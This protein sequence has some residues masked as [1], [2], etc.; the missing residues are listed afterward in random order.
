MFQTPPSK[1]KKDK[2]KIDQRVRLA[3][4]KFLDA[5]PTKN[6]A[7]LNACTESLQN[8]GYYVDVDFSTSPATAVLIRA[9]DNTATLTS[10]VDLP[11]VTP[12]KTPKPTKPAP[13]QPPP[14]MATSGSQ[15]SAVHAY[16]GSTDVDIYLL[17]AD[18]MQAS[19]AW[20]NAV[21]RTVVQNK[22]AGDAAIWYWNAIKFGEDLDSKAALWAAL[23]S[24]F[25][26]AF[27]ED[28]AS[29][30]IVNLKQKDSE[31]VH[32]FF[33]RTI[34]AVDKLNHA[35]T[36]AQKKQADYLALMHTHV[37][38]FFSAGLR[39]DISALCMAGAKPPRTA[40]DLLDAAVAIEIQQEKKKQNQPASF[41]AEVAAA[42]T[43]KPAPAA[44]D[45]DELIKKIEAL[46]NK[47]FSR[48]NNPNRGGFRSNY[49]GRGRGG[50]PRSG[51]NP[52]VTCYNC[53]RTGHM[54]YECRSAPANPS[55]PTRGNF[56]RRG[57]YRNN[58]GNG[59]RP[60]SSQ[61]T[62]SSQEVS[63]SNIRPLLEWEVEYLN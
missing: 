48:Q 56:Q 15:I 12:V 40:K 29:K 43:P 55:N 53:R 47:R 46:F 45:E 62:S 52:N 3:F 49:R 44:Q 61:P 41:V 28:E 30:A 34:A 39:S 7:V 27:N 4:Q 5:Y 6:S 58:Y 10:D 21:I 63:Q 54:S 36:P 26:A 59:F 57:G 8:L 42:D 1:D 22:L 2:D 24:R 35:Y 13:T 14:T 37:F 51:Y 20:D 33:S 17:H 18:T 50:P 19:F 16:D 9:S 31:S 32:T 60:S 23:R 25:G 11:A 38:T